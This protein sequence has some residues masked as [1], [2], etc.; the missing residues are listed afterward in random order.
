[1]LLTPTY[2]VFEMYKVHQDA[3]LLP[4]E[5]R[6]DDYSCGEHSM[7]S[8]S[9][10][11]SRDESGQVHL[12]LCNL[13]PRQ[14]A[15]VTCELRGMTP[16]GTGGRVLTAEQMQAHNTFDAPDTVRPAAFDGATLQGNQLTI[17]LPPMSVVVLELR[18]A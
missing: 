16:S 1:M 14:S 13:N 8:L 7:P 11:A 4:L 18:N 15:D 17:T 5:L 10:S 3:T 6:C 2:H 12:S 9:A